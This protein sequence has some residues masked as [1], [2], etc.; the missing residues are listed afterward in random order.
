[1]SRFVDRDE[2]GRI[3]GTYACKQ[4]PDQEELPD[5]HSDLV[6]FETYLKDPH[7]RLDIEAFAT[8][9]VEKLD[10]KVR[11]FVYTRYPQHRQITLSKLLTDARLAGKQQAIDYL[12]LCDNWLKLVFAAYYSAEDQIEAIAR[13]NVKDTATKK[14]EIAAVV[15][16]LDLSNLSAIDPK[17]TIRHSL[18]LLMS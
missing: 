17:T 3:N 10:V 12:T 15:D 11:E 5:G 8:K 2:K 18:E 9:Q 14:T 7:T 1:M 6:E 16:T 4:R 13:D